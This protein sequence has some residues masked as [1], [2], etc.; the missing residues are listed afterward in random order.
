MFFF[1]NIFFLLK[2]DTQ[3]AMEI[4]S[5]PWWTPRKTDGFHPDKMVVG[6]CWFVSLLF[7][8]GGESSGLFCDYFFWGVLGGSSQLV[9]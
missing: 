2:Y 5:F 8:R 9:L 1:L 6:L 3:V 4:P 7:Q